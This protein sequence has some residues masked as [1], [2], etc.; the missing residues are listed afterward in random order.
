MLITGPNGPPCRSGESRGIRLTPSTSARVHSMWMAGWRRQLLDSRPESAQ[1]P[2]PTWRRPAWMGQ[3]VDVRRG[4]VAAVFGLISLAITGTG[5]L[6]DPASQGEWASPYEIGVIPIHATL[7][8][9]DVILSF[10]YPEGPAATDHTSR[11]ATVNWKTHQV[12]DASATYDRDF[13]C[14]GHVVLGDGRVWVSG[15][16]DHMTGKKQDG[17]GV[18][19]TDLWDPLMRSWTPTTPLTQKRWYPTT[20]GLADGMTTLTFGGHENNSVPANTVDRYDAQTNTMVRLPDSASQN[21][22]NY[23]R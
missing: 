13:F 5:V 12:L 18:A 3:G 19:N 1:S 22:G 20:V 16:H 15:G 4:I 10:E 9:D 23:P 21:F 7:T 14:A 17:V 11:V 6:A 8:H 2:G